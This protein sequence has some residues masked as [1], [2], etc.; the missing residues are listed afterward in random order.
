MGKTR[1]DH[2]ER[3]NV[4]DQGNVTRGAEEM[5]QQSGAL[6]ARVEDTDSVPSTHMA[7]LNCFFLGGDLTSSSDLH[8]HGT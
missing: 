8:G 2:T 3:V 1:E 6:A 5:A 7:P 4:S